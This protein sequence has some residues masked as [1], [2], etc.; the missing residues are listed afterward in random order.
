MCHS[1]DI[2][3]PH[4]DLYPTAPGPPQSSQGPLPLLLCYLLKDDLLSKTIYLLTVKCLYIYLCIYRWA[5]T[6]HNKYTKVKGQF[7]IVSFLPHV[8]PKDQ[9]QVIRGGRPLLP[10]WPS[11]R[12]KFSLDV[13][14]SM[15]AGHEAYIFNS[16]IHKVETRGWRVLK[17]QSRDTVPG[18]PW[19]YSPEIFHFSIQPLLLSQL[20][21]IPFHVYTLICS[22]RLQLVDILPFST[23]SCN[24]MNILSKHWHGGW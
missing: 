6:R 9:T 15:Q 24:Q 8:R 23:L 4:P 20:H 19:Q 3:H 12:P 1:E 18:S 10:V 14:K 11:A 2:Y 22:T 5:Y 7:L 13:F 21:C 16:S 17:S